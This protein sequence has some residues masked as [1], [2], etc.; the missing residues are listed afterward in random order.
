MSKPVCVVVG[1]GP[2]NGASCAKKFDQAGY[3][4]ALLARNEE[5]L[6]EFAAQLNEAKGYPCD[7]AEVRQI[8]DAFQK[9]NEDF[10]SID[11]LIYNAGSGVFNNIEETSVEEFENAW[12]INTRG[13]LVASQQVIPG[14][15]EAGKGNIVIVG[16]TASLKGGANFAPF[17]SSK[18]AQRSLAQSM[19]RHLGPKGIHVSYVIID[20]VIDLPR[21]RQWMSDKSD[22]DFMKADD[23]AK[24]IFSLTEQPKSAWSFEID[25]RPFGEK[26]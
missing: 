6:S 15:L 25:L 13:C 16:A 7:V 21:T 14:M 11:T 4:V 9:I 12:Q 19:A 10:G 3:R 23:I 1:L 5:Y 17:A 18:A 22:E 24:S 8:E 2:G 20:G 26:W